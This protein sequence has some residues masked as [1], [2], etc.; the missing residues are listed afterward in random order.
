MQFSGLSAFPLTPFTH[1]ADG[2]EEVDERA[3]AALIERLADAG[4][5]SI[6]ALGSTGSYAYLSVAERARVAEVAVQ[7]AGDTPVIVGVGALRTRDVLANIAHAESAGAAALQLAPLAYQPL[8]DDDVYGLFRAA[9]EAS[10]LPVIVYDN[11]ATTHVTF[12]LELYARIAALPGIASFKIP[13]IPLEENE[14]RARVEQIRAVIPEHVTIGIS[15][16]AV[17][18]TGLLAG[19]DAWYSVIGGTLPEPALRITRASLAGD[20][21]TARAESDRLAPLWRLNAELGGSLRVV[22]AVA[23]HLGLAPTR[24][25]PLPLEGLTA[26]DRARVAEAL[27][28]IET[29]D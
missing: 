5:D 23:E 20:R 8:T 14:F 1:S 18:T 21:V 22:A 4:V 9:S 10:E 6:A 26:A 28:R 13:G 11:P 19:C 15:G 7:H 17:A 3:F 24:C 12:T 2:G 29:R 16:D 27:K 25:L